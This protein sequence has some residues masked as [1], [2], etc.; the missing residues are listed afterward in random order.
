MGFQLLGQSDKLFYKNN[1]NISFHF[2]VLLKATF[3]DQSTI[4]T[5]TLIR[6]HLWIG[7]TTFLFEINWFFWERSYVPSF[8]ISHCMLK[9]HKNGCIRLTRQDDWSCQVIPSVLWPERYISYQTG[10]IIGDTQSH[11]KLITY[12]SMISYC[13][14]STMDTP[15]CKYF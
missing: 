9:R 4:H 5:C 12:S 13:L 1:I 10:K 15:K 11:G 3:T 6:Y 2:R 8:E 14:E 7:K